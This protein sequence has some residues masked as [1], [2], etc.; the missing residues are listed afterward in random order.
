M[1]KNQDT[2]QD[3]SGT[4]SK[5]TEGDDTATSQTSKS[6]RNASVEGPTLSS[7]SPPFPYS[8]AEQKQ[9]YVQNGWWDEFEDL[10]FDAEFELRQTFE[11]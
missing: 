11:V 3:L 9:M 5:S 2:D 10:E 7:S 6:S 1:T 8:D 4:A